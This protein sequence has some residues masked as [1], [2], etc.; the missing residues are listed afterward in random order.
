MT[1]DVA[2]PAHNS[3]LDFAFYTGTQFPAEY[4]GGAFITLHGTWNRSQR[5]GYKVVY[6]PFQNGRPSGQPRD[7]LTGWMIAP[8]N[9]DVWGRPV[10]VIM[11]PDGSLLVS[12]DGGKKIWRVSYGGRRAT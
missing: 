5:A 12:D 1:P 11:L 4:R 10:G 7:F 2:L 9:R 8:A 3:P 6:V